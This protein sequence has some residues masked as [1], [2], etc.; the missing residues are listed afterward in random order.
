MYKLMYEPTSFTPFFRPA[1]YAIYMG[2]LYAAP[3]YIVVRKVFVLSASGDSTKW[4]IHESLILVI[5]YS[6]IR[7]KISLIYWLYLQHFEHISCLFA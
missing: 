4:S 1:A 6:A 7:I 3:L 2:K 5:S